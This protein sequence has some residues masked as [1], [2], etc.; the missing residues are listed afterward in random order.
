M[1]AENDRDCL[2]SEEKL[3]ER[4]QKLFM[5]EFKEMHAYFKGNLRDEVN[6]LL[7]EQGHKQKSANF[8]PKR[9]F[10]DKINAFDGIFGNAMDEDDSHHKRV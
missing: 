10:L 1:L 3:D 5:K 8:N 7:Q 4:E 2:P 9:Q 6:E